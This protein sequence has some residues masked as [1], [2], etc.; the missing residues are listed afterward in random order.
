MTDGI[1]SDTKNTRNANDQVVDMFSKSVF[2]SGLLESIK[3]GI[4]SGK[5]DVLILMVGLDDSGKTTIL[6]K[7]MLGEIV[8]IDSL[9]VNVKQV[10]YKNIRFTVCNVGAHD[11]V[12]PVLRNYFQNIQGLIFLVDSNDRGDRVNAAR[13]ELHRMLN[14]DA[15]RDAVLLVANK[16]D[17]PNT[18]SAAEITDEL[19][20][21]SLVQLQ[22][23]VQ[24]TCATSEEGLY[25]GL[26]WLLNN[27]AADK[28]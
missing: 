20:L 8:T 15:P 16:K 26:D 14:E 5:K 17:L 13:D 11:K 9:G 23:H 6:H 22:W 7:L 10:V 18:V 3:P 19:G 1:M 28:G 24:T 25:E 27:I 21:R 2:P 4:L 12:L